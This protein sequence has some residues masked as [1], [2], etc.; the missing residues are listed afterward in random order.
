[1]SQ[2]LGFAIEL[3][4]DPAL[5]NQVLKAWNVLARRQISTHLIEMESRPHITLFS[6]PFLEPSKLESLLKG[7]ASKHDPLPLTFSSLATFPNDP[8]N[9]LFLAPTP[10]LSLLHLQSQLCDAIRKEGLEIGDDYAFNS[11]IPYC[12]VAHHVP[13]NRMPEAFS[14]LRELKLPVSGYAMDIALVQ[15]SP[16]REI[17]SFV[18]GNNVDS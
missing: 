9:L 14:L 13:K 17:F 1:M 12:S 18:L 2:Q 4:L 11:W 8:D 16:V 10:S 5:E 7:F 15:F 6:A 3:Y